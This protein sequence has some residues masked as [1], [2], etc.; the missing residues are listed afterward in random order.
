MNSCISMT[1][2]KYSL[3]FGDMLD[4]CR[5][6]NML[7]IDSRK[8]RHLMNT[9]ARISTFVKQETFQIPLSRLFK[10]KKDNRQDG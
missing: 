3:A 9:L 2:V 7:M 6:K 4:L 10:I 8:K 5:G 1:F